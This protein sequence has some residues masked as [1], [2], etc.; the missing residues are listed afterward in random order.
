MSLNETSWNFE[1]GTE[2]NPLQYLLGITSSKQVKISRNRLQTELL[3]PPKN[4]QHGSL[5]AVWAFVETYEDL[6]IFSVS[7][8]GLLH[9]SDQRCLRS[10]QFVFVP[11][12]WMNILLLSRVC[13][14]FVRQ[15]ATQSSALPPYFNVDQIFTTSASGWLNSRV[16]HILR[17]QVLRRSGWWLYH[18]SSLHLHSSLFFFQLFFFPACF[19][20]NSWLSVCFSSL[21]V[22]W[23]HLFHICYKYEYTL[24]LHKASSLICHSQLLLRPCP[25]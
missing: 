11:L 9:L 10:L 7:W 13:A 25:V 16:C 21:T 19:F 24:W 5:L 17:V 20:L 1:A 12:T 23:F 3:E 2:H 14:S 22:L 18:A 15:S 6:I 4:L 8:C